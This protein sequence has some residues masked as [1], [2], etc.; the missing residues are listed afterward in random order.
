MRHPKRL[1]TQLNK[2][3]TLLSTVSTEID[4]NIYIHM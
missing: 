3:L 2:R 1:E 4:K